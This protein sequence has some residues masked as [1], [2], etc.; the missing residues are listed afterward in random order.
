MPIIM[1]TS[2]QLMSQLVG[3]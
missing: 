3:S 1:P 2:M